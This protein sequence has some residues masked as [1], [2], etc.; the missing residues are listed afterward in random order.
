MGNVW[1]FLPPLFLNLGTVPGCNWP[2]MAYG[3]FKVGCLMS[4]F[5]FSSV[6]P[7]DPFDLMEF[8]LL[9]PVA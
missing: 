5:A 3:Y 4:L 1:N 7:M 6:V 9:K 8:P 2:M